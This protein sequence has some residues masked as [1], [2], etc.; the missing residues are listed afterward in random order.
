MKRTLTCFTALF[1]VLGLSTGAL[2]L[3]SSVIIDGQVYILQ[4]QGYVIPEQQVGG[5]ETG[6]VTISGLADADPAIT[7]G[8]AVVDFGA[9]STFGFS[10]AIPL[11]FRPC[12]PP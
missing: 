3:S 12:P 1:L 5:T 11:C 2:A 7:Y 10:F 9:P 6:M 4:T 8:V